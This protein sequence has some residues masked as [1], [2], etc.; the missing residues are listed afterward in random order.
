MILFFLQKN[1][2]I[3]TLTKL[4]LSMKQP[5]AKKFTSNVKHSQTFKIFKK[6][7]QRLLSKVIHRNLLIS[8]LLVKKTYLNTFYH[9]VL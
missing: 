7:I 3:S 6:K 5:Q 9:I 8:L 1:Y 2:G 4:N